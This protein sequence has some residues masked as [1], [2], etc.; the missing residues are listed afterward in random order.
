MAKDY[1]SHDYN[2]RNDTK[3][4]KVF[5]EYGLEGVGAYWC[6]I[7]ML[8]EEG[9]YLLLSEYERITFELRT[10]EKMI[11]DIINKYDLFEKDIDK[12]WSESALER[13][14]LRAEKSEKARQS[15][16]KRWDKYERNTNVKETNNERNTSKGKESKV[17]ERKEKEEI[18]KIAP[19]DFY[20]SEL[21]LATEYKKQYESFVNIIFGKNDI[22]TEL[23]NIINL[24][25][26]V[27]YKQFTKLWSL[28]NEHEKSIAES[29]LNINDNKNYTKNRS[30]LYLIMRKWIKSEYK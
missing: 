16:Q 6:I 19:K 9:G 17:K 23:I 25:L 24:E 14:N 15:I 1:F 3:L 8:Y 22:D 7:E 20:K 2:A 28:K 10:N 29:L 27:T 11:N 5:M 12:F 18:R 21:E 26:Q 13:L 4:I 30:S